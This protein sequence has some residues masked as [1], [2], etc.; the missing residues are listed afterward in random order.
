MTKAWLLLSPG[1]SPDGPDEPR[2]LLAKATRPLWMLGGGRLPWGLP[3]QLLAYLLPA[4]TL[5]PTQNEMASE[6]AE[7]QDDPTQEYSE[8]RRRAQ[9]SVPRH[10]QP[11]RSVW[12]TLGGS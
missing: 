12:N 9:P 5:L 11:R 8:P 6:G 10:E 2:L 4:A 1:S 3:L 7:R